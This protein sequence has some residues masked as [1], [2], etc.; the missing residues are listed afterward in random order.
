MGDHPRLCREQHI[1]LFF[2]YVEHVCRR[3]LAWKSIESARLVRPTFSLISL[4]MD[5][6]KLILLACSVLPSARF[7]C[8]ALPPLNPTGYCGASLSNCKTCSTCTGSTTLAPFHDSTPHFALP[9][10]SK[11]WMP[12]LFATCAYRLLLR[13]QPL[14][15]PVTMRHLRACG[16]GTA[17]PAL[18]I[19]HASLKCVS[20]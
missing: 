3:L 18:E 2:E 11:M 8:S 17:S 15:N 16:A 10:P 13:D 4:S 9:Q 1:A 7:C 5:F 6:S 20:C 19:T 12:S 14:G